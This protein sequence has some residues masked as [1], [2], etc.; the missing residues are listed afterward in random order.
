MPGEVDLTAWWIGYGIAAAVIVVVVAVVG[1]ILLLARSIRDQARTI[2][3]V[4]ERIEGNTAPLWGLQD[5]N[6]RLSGI[7]EKAASLR[8]SLAR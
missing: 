3:L 4:L 1:T 6:V 2:H 8:E 5:T 7:V